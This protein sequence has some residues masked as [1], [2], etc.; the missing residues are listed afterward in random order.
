LPI[1]IF[2][3]EIE[4]ALRVINRIKIDSGITMAALDP[5]RLISALA[6]GL[7]VTPILLNI[8][9]LFAPSE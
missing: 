4:K 5:K 9:A 2:L 3:K 7:T 1:S 6:V 8:F